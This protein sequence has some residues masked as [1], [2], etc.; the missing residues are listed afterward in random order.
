MSNLVCD[1]KPELKLE[2]V[3]ENEVSFNIITKGSHK[4]YLW[5]C[6]KCESHY[7]NSVA[8]QYK[9]FKCPYCHGKKVNHT[10]SLA[11]LY[12]SIASEWHSER[13][14]NLLPSEVTYGSSQLV[15]WKCSINPKHEWEAK[16]SM[17]TTKGTNCPYCSGRRVVSDE[18]SIY[19]THPDI[20]KMFLDIE[21][22]KEYSIGMDKKV[23]W[24]CGCGEVVKGKR[25]S[26]VVQNGLSCPNCSRT[27]RQSYPERYV[28]SL[29]NT[30]DISYEVEK[31]FDFAKGC[32]Y[33]FYIENLSCVIEVHGKQHYEDVNF[34]SKTVLAEESMSKDKKK[35]EYCLNNG[36]K[37]Y[38]VVEAKVSEPSYIRNSIVNSGL[39]DVLEIKENEIDWIEVSTKA[40]TKNLVSDCA[41]LYDEGL[42]IKQISESLNINKETVRKYLKQASS[43]GMCSYS[44]RKNKRLEVKQISLDGKVVKVWGSV[45]E[46]IKHYDVSRHT[47]KKCLDG[48]SS[49]V[50]GFWWE[51][52]I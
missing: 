11:S 2:W 6:L 46:I 50:C 22:S 37:F 14:G 35:M 29:L 30:L 20:A 48:G 45:S 38:I 12:P 51:Y 17:R 10:N 13:N 5:K 49:S 32:R 1:L 8:N 19:V 27:G 47:L 41:K 15:W 33:D 26:N 24:K 3:E 39:L 42:N 34:G 40:I 21:L 28:W 25:I 9:G 4:K 43:S 52:N 23:D 16:V 44:L 31:T 36:I 18:N 7:P